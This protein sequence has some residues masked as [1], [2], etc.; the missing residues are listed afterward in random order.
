MT[1]RHRVSAVLIRDKELLL[2]RREN[3]Q[4]VYY[5]FPGGGIENGETAEEAAVREVREEAGIAV[6]PQRIVTTIENENGNNVFIVCEQLDMREPVWQE[7]E[8]QQPD[9]TYAFVWVLIEELALH[10]ILPIQ[11]KEVV[12]ASV[13]GL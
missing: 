12:I 11:A 6:E 9:N 2:V 1:I 8:K 5:V 13:S 4:G 10:T 7:T 3:A